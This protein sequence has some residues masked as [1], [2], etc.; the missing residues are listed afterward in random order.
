MQA[1]ENKLLRLMKS[2]KFWTF[3]AAAVGVA[4]AYGTGH[5]DGWQAIQAFIAAAAAYSLGTGIED[6]GKSATPPTLP[7]P[8]G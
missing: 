2:R 6:N 1:Y 5:I 4:A 3:V 8:Q 7:P